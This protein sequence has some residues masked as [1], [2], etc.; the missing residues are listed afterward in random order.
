MIRLLAVD[1]DGTLV[2]VDL[3][4]DP[5]DVEAARKAEAAGIRVVACDVVGF[6]VEISERAP[7]PSYAHGGSTS[8]S[9]NGLP[10]H[11]R[12]RLHRLP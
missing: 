12:S 1:L 7:K 11:L 3:R 2:S 4:L 5:R 6:L 10:F 9:P 8:S